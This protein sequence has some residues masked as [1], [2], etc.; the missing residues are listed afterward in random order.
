[1]HALDQKQ[2]RDNKTGSRTAN[3]LNM[4]LDSNMLLQT[5]TGKD[6]TMGA[7]SVASQLPH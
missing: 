1:M 5:G 6:I 3:S 2:G 7:D 4:V